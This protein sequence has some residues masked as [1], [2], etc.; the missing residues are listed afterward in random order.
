MQN[1]KNRLDSAST[2]LHYWVLIRRKG[3]CVELPAANHSCSG[4]QGF[5][6]LS[7]SANRRVEAD[8]IE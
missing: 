3:I 2:P 4:L 5:V 1:A 8:G 7:V 6:L